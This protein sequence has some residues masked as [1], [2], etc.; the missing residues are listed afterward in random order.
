MSPAADA[1]SSEACAACKHS[2]A[3][4]VLVA[5][6][7]NA[8]WRFAKRLL[9]LGRRSQPELEPVGQLVADVVEL[10]PREL[11]CE[12]VGR[13]PL[14]QRRGA[15]KRHAESLDRPGN[16]QAAALGRLAH[17]G[18]HA[19]SELD[20]EPARGPIKARDVRLAVIGYFAS[21]IV[22]REPELHYP[23]GTLSAQRG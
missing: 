16:E 1:A 5:A 2:S 14:G 22:R 7:T 15:D 18:H 9:Q 21:R 17:A 23:H 20:G 12:R 19:I 10:S 8:F 6:T 4:S 13:R 3:R 11:D